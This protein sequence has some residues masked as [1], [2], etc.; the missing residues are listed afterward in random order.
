MITL[1][2]SIELLREAYSTSGPFVLSIQATEVETELIPGP[3]ESSE[4]TLAVVLVNTENRAPRFMSKRYVAT[5]EE[6]SPSLTSVT[7]EGPEIPKVFDDDQ[8]K[9]GS[10]ELFLDGD[11]GAFS[12]QP[13][14]GMNELNFAIL[15]KDPLQL[16]YETSD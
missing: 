2:S 11:G 14:R 5:V 4:A 3:P 1:A 12:V 16:D 10:F 6:N 8:G 15:V 13:G 7:W 9:N